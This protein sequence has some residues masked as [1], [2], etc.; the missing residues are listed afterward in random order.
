METWKIVGYVLRITALIVAVLWIRLS[1]AR[2]IAECANHVKS[3]RKEAA[4]RAAALADWLRA[5][6]NGGLD[7]LLYHPGIGVLLNE[8][9][10]TGSSVTL[11]L[12]GKCCHPKAK[13]FCNQ[14]CMV[15]SA[16]TFRFFPI[17]IHNDDHE[18]FA[19]VIDEEYGLEAMV[20]AIN[21]AQENS[22]GVV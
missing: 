18:Y 22:V 10:F 1:Y 13:R 6:G 4:K 5:G 2:V 19:M 7:V 3:A 15:Y 14:T 21:G 20:R 8:R 17:K 16:V 11:S 9:P 12:V